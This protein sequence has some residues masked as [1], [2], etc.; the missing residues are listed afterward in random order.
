[1]NYYGFND[2]SLGPEF[3][4]WEEK[5]RDGRDKGVESKA[6]RILRFLERNKDRAFYSSDIVKAL[7]V[8]P[9]DVM[10]NVRRFE[11][12][13]LVFVRGYQSHDKRSPFRRGYV[14]TWIDQ[15]KPREEA[16]KEAFERT[17]KVLFEGS[18]SN[19]VLERVRMIRDQ[20]LVAKDLLSTDYFQ[21]VLRCS[22][23]Q[24]KRAL[25]RAMQLYPDIKV[26][27]IFDRYSY[28]Y[29]ES[30]SEEDFKACLELKKNYIRKA[31]GRDNRLGHN[32]EA[33]VEWFIDRFTVGAKF[34]TQSHR[35]KMD[36]RRITLHL[37]K[38]V[39]DRKQNAEVDRVWEVTPG[40]FSP[41]VTYVL[42]CKWSVVTRR[43]LDEFIEVLKWSTDFGVDT[44]G[45]RALK[46][47]I[48]P[49]FGAG[50]FNPREKIVVNGK[51]ITLAQ[52]ASQ[53]NIQLLKPGDFNQKLREYG[54]LKDVTVQ[55][56][57]RACRDEKEVREVLDKIWK[58][59]DK[60]V[61]ILNQVVNRNKDIFSF[62]KMLEK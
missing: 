34:W 1:M 17:S 56:I 14:I 60:A 23:D 3:V 36:P 8:K 18:T 52:Y 19:A 27:N 20:L 7:G 15:S 45:G 57:C 38:P 5:L 28:Y 58:N 48:I 49:V 41:T 21:D 29:L 47:G 55:K 31:K 4:V 61:A 35:S 32:W 25:K 39:G 50:A 44:E 13:G 12:K 33:V 51:T 9:C 54:V 59:P 40:L 22:R 24:V 30:M 6:S 46:N 37:L 11:R 62:E 26:V 43:T 16:V 42:E 53:R 10:P 2:G